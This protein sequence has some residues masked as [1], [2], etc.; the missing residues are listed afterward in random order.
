M[1]QRSRYSHQ[2]CPLALQWA[3]VSAR[4]K[5]LLSFHT[6]TLC[7]QTVLWSVLWL[8]TQLSL[9]RIRQDKTIFSSYLCIRINFLYLFTTVQPPRPKDLLFISFFSFYSGT[10]TTFFF[11]RGVS[12][13]VMMSHFFLSLDLLNT[14]YVWFHE[15]HLAFVCVK[16]CGRGP[17]SLLEPVGAAAAAAAAAGYGRR[18]RP[19][20][21]EWLDGL[22]T[23]KTRP[24]ACPASLSPYHP[25]MASGATPRPPDDVR[26]DRKSDIAYVF[27][28]IPSDTVVETFIFFRY[29]D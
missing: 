10:P 26:R 8:S 7:L 28:F 29:T 2:I 5:T 9:H 11:S 3:S 22:T 27:I 18:G 12:K 16:E 25:I 20:G 23:R 17:P 13:P 21:Q 24:P 6:L 15:G 19:P 1:L 4:S 14:D